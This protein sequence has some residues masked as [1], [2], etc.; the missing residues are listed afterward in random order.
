MPEKSRARLSC[1]CEVDG[2]V[3]LDGEALVKV[4]SEH[5]KGQRPV[6]RL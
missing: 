3:V 4:P 6:M 5:G 1:L 2:E